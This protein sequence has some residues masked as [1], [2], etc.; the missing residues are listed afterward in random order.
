MTAL[1]GRVK[2]VK[3]IKIISNRKTRNVRK[4]RI[5]FL[6]QTI[7]PTFNKMNKNVI[8][9]LNFLHIKHERDCHSRVK[10]HNRMVGNGTITK[11]S[12]T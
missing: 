11:I 9:R 3:R 4:I 6:P 2:R 1:V 5:N 8:N 7:L 12:R 10:E